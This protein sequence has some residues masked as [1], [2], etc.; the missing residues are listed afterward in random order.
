MEGFI[1]AVADEKF[2]FKDLENVDTVTVDAHADDDDNVPLE[3]YDFGKDHLSKHP[4]GKTKE[5]KKVAYRYRK[6]RDLYTSP[7]TITSEFSTLHLQ[8]CC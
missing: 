2:F 1:F 8:D 7:N 4:K 3:Q 5:M 6:I